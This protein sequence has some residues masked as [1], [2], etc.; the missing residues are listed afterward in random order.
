M[1]ADPI[2]D[3]SK[4]SKM[5]SEGKTVKDCAEYF[6]VSSAAVSKAKKRLGLVVAKHIQLESAYRF[7]GQHL[8]AVR[9]LKDINKVTFQLLEE[10]T[11]E[12]ETT[13]RMVQAVQ[14][15]LDYE[16][17]PTNDKL[18]DLKALI[19]R[20][21]QDKNTAIRACAEIRGQLRLQNETLAMLTEMKGVYEFQQELIQLLK[22]IDQKVKDEFIRR[23][24]QKQA[25]RRVIRLD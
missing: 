21:N 11:G 23:L 9:Q 16:K 2:I 10:L 14:A 13:N 1:P 5:L 6:N 15:V 22:D 3:V 20:I 4:L 24:S 8:D 12:E 18:K 25:L 19:L 7:V 17:E